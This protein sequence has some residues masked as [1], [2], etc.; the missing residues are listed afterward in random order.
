MVGG[1]VTAA[2]YGR[3]YMRALGRRGVKA[4]NGRRA[5]RRLGDMRGDPRARK[6]LRA[7]ESEFAEVAMAE[8]N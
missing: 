8:T 1:M 6:V 2:R 4:G 3:P 7:L 5:L